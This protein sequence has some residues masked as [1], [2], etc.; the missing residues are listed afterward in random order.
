MQGVR[1]LP[2]LVA[3]RAWG[4]QRVWLWPQSQLRDEEAGQPAA[5]LG[6]PRGI[7]SSA[8]GCEAPV[9][10]RPTQEGLT[11]PPL[12]RLPGPAPAALT[13]HWA[14]R[15]KRKARGQAETLEAARPL[16][17]S[18][19]NEHVPRCCWHR[20]PPAPPQGPDHLRPAPPGSWS[21]RERC[22]G[23]AAARPIQTP[24]M[25]GSRL[26]LGLLAPGLVRRQDS[27]QPSGRLS[28][29]PAPKPPQVPPRATL[30]PTLPCPDSLALAPQP[31]HSAAP[32]SQHSPKH[33]TSL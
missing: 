22:Q 29:R 16:L 21:A 23:P 2:G 13:P 25:P 15:E 11:H 10:Q 7:G 32:H 17:P 5:A 19:L 24:S 30:R 8:L 31:P 33:C 18:P 26:L 3:S 12:G 20:A 28:C 9:G 27:G 1:A 4:R 14:H 6:M